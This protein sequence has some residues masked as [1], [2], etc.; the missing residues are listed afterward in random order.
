M[1][2]NTANSL[3]AGVEVKIGGALLD[4][5]V[6]ARLIELRVEDN[7]TLPDS[8]EIKVS[9]PDLTMVDRPEFAIGKPVT[10]AF[11]GKS[12]GAL[13][14]VLEGE[15][16]SL[17]PEFGQSAT[18]VVRG[19]DV[20][21]RMNRSRVAATYQQVT[22]GDIAKKLISQNG[23]AAG[24]VDHTGGVHPFVQQNNQ[25]DWEFLWGLARKIDFELVVDAKKAHF[26]KA[27][28]VVPGPTL[29]W[30]ETL[31]SFRPRAT[32]VQQVKEVT[33]RGWDPK[34]KKEIVGQGRLSSATHS[35]KIGLDAQSLGKQLA[36]GV[37]RITNV[38]VDSAGDATAMAES[39]LARMANAGV[40]GTGVAEGDPTLR[41]GTTIAIDGVGTKFS[42]KY[43]VT[44]TSHV[45]RSAKGYETRFTCGGRS[46]RSLVDLMN[47]SRPK[48]FGNS[49]VVG[50]V[51]N[52]TD[53]DKLGRVKV[54][55]PE[56]GDDAETF[57]ARLCLPNAGKERGLIMI[58]QVN[59]EVVIGFLHDQPEYPY[60]LGSVWNGKD[61][62]GP[63]LS[64]DDPSLRVRTPKDMDVKATENIILACDK[65]FTVTVKGVVKQTA[66]GNITV[67]TK[68][69]SSQ[70]ATGAMEIEGQT[71]TI[72]G[73]NITVQASASLTLKGATVSL[74][75][76]GPVNIK[77]AII[78]LG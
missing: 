35:A 72:K 77:G 23:L 49:V 51:T 61:T 54:K 12:A 70:K 1:S 32:G 6:V 68:G 22:Y 10:I 69:K 66:D 17:E 3:V 55:L 58:P 44:S 21:H 29:V 26:R 27:S 60:V 11:A 9:D 45:Y 30:G 53:P 74:E 71:V 37:M 7:L 5:T 2:T 38:P 46:P 41:A 16:T 63:D 43:K 73:T 67:E 8:F 14:P 28:T 24:T 15:I 18:L 40:E 4:P 19:Y 34:T 33:V 62:P 47:R 59:D 75:G 78:N 76:S 50:I 42:G 25:T 31:R 65:D 36:G 20:S 48:G 52:N 57:W 56:L 13:T 64:K 39:V